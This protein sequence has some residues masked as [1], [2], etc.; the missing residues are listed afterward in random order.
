MPGTMGRTSKFP[1][2]E[3]IH[4]HVH[5]QEDIDS[6]RNKDPI[7]DG[8]QALAL[9]LLKLAEEA[10]ARGQGQSCWHVRLR[11]ASQARHGQDA[12]VVV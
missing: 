9:E 5:V 7:M 11:G 2:L 1:L 12:D 3:T 8:G 4:Y 10:W 6:V